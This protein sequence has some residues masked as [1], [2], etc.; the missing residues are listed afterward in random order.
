MERNNLKTVQTPFGIDGRITLVTDP[1]YMTLGVCLAADDVREVLLP[2]IRNGFI[3]RD[4]KQISRD[5]FRAAYSQAERT[6]AEH[7]QKWLRDVLKDREPAQ[8]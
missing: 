5:L 3:S 7:I 6:M 1:D 8:H 4:P 2:A